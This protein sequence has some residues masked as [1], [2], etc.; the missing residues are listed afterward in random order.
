MNWSGHRSNC[1]ENDNVARTI[2]LTMRTRPIKF[3]ELRMKEPRQKSN[4]YAKT[5]RINGAY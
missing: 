2:E 1:V 5:R 3:G 4:V